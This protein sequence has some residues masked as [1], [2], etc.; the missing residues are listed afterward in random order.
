MINDVS[1]AIPRD[2]SVG[3]LNRFEA[4]GLSSISLDCS[5]NAKV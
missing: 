5:P 1:E 2:P 4:M 3:I